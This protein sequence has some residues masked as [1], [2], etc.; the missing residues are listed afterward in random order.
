MLGH[1]WLFVCLWAFAMHAT[2]VLMFWERGAGP[3]ME[4]MPGHEW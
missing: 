4:L 1:E 3:I 2:I